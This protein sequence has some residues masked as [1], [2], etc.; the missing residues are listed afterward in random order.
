M[1]YQ[2]RSRILEDPSLVAN[3]G[4]LGTRLEVPSRRWQ[5]EQSPYVAH[6]Q[7][8]EENC[9]LCGQHSTPAPGKSAFGNG[10]T[11]RHQTSCIYQTH[12]LPFP[13]WHSKHQS[14][15]PVYTALIL[16]HLLPPT[17]QHQYH[18]FP[19]LRAFECAMPTFWNPLPLALPVN[20]T[21]YSLFNVAT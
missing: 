12:H 14:T 20:F 10:I 7:L 21:F 9:A 4:M 6:G 3:I 15:I 5:G 18:G 19:C 16:N 1:K 8:R 2:T 17:P 11:G 13:T